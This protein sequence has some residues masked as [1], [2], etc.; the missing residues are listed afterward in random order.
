MLG[1]YIYHQDGTLISKTGFFHTFLSL[2]LRAGSA[3][4]LA[5]WVGGAGA[6]PRDAGETR[7][8][9]QAHF[10]SA[11]R[12]VKVALPGRGGPPGHPG[13]GRFR[14]GYRYRPGLAERAVS[15][16]S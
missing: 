15:A 11:G 4:G 5:R 14:D 7:G 9:G 16:T 1:I 12:V 6:S 13:T 10:Q 3:R 8:G 2:R